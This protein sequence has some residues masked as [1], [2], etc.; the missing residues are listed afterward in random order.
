M[1]AINKVTLGVAILGLMLVFAGTPA[2]GQL[3]QNLL[4]Y[5]MCDTAPSCDPPNRIYRNA[6]KAGRLGNFTEVEQACIAEWESYNSWWFCKEGQHEIEHSIRNPCA[7]FDLESGQGANAEILIDDY[8]REVHEILDFTDTAHFNYKKKALDWSMDTHP[9]DWQWRENKHFSHGALKGEASA[10]WDPNDGNP[11]TVGT[12]PVEASL[13][14]YISNGV[15]NAVQDATGQQMHT[16][17]ICHYINRRQPKSSQNFMLHLEMMEY[18]DDDGDWVLE[19]G[20]IWSHCVGAGQGHNTQC[21]SFD[22]DECVPDEADPF[23]TII[24]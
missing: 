19:K 14:D 17:L 12:V 13:G 2:F 9:R 1:R 4:K 6:E 21:Q 10:I 18:L 3:G 11:V 20:H 23:S 5:S 24:P 16:V 8:D 15:L 22:P 7:R